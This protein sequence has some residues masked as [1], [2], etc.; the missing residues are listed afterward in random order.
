MATT[1]RSTSVT[2]PS[3]EHARET[4]RTLRR[5][6]LDLLV[7]GLVNFGLVIIWALSGVGYFWPIWVIVGWGMALVIHA[8]VTGTLPFARDFL[9]FLQPDWEEQKVKELLDRRANRSSS[10][11]SSNK[12]T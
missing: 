6:Y 8:A 10:D 9:P 2:P 4:A 7:Y 3:E 5:L 12:A 11:E 1:K